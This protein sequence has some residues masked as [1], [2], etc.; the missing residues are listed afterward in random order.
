MRRTHCIDCGRR[1]HAFVHHT[2]KRCD[3]CTGV[4]TEAD[5]CRLLEMGTDREPGLCVICGQETQTK[6][7]VYCQDCL[8]RK[9]KA[10]Y[11]FDLRSGITAARVKVYNQNPVNAARKKAY[12]KAYRN[13]PSQK[14]KAKEYWAAWY[15]IPENKE[16]M[17]THNKAWLQNP[18]N[19]RKKLT[20]TM[21]G[22]RRREQQRE[23]EHLSLAGV[24]RGTKG[25]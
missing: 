13:R 20:G 15:Q 23:L 12:L 17:R 3:V 21:A 9:S 14:A 24:L 5:W 7:R 10:Q 1:F 16:R 18:E 6:R 25:V 2:T 8:D 19:Y 22:K 4:C 11:L